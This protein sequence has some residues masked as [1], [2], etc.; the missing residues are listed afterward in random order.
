VQCLGDE[1]LGDLGTV[2]IG[3]VDEGHTDL[4]GSTEHAS[5]FFG[6]CRLAPDAGASEAHGAEA[7]PVDRRILSQRDGAGSSGVCGGGVF[8]FWIPDTGVIDVVHPAG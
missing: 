5:A 7:H 8:H 2:G 1:S 6:I 4:Y 3:G